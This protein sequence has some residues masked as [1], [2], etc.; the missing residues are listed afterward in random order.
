MYTLNQGWL[1]D[2]CI[3]NFPFSLFFWGEWRKEVRAPLTSAELTPAFV[4]SSH[5]WQSSRG[6]YGTQGIKST[7]VVCK[8]SVL[9]TVL[10]CSFLPLSTLVSRVSKACPAAGEVEYFCR[11]YIEALGSIEEHHIGV[12]PEH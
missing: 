2:L 3:V 10:F 9:Y 11:E 8:A 12:I 7:T 6:P 4:L 5:F 1:K